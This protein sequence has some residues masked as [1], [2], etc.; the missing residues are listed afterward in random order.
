MNLL[1]KLTIKNLKLNKK[2]TIVT[3]I[4]IVLSIA[5]LTAVSS[6]YKSGLDAL[7]NYEKVITG[8]YH[9]KFSNVKKEDLDKINLHEG[10][11]FASVT[12]G[13]G[14]AKVPSVNEAKPYVYILGYTKDSFNQLGVKLE[15][16]RLPE[17]DSEVLVPNHLYTNGRVNYQIGDKITLDVGSRYINGEEVDQT[18][19]YEKEETF[20]AKTKKEY[21]VVGTIGSP[22]RQVEAFSAPGYSLIT[23]YDL[24]DT[25]TYNVYIRF[26]ANR[27]KD[28]YSYIAD[29]EGINKDIFVKAT[30]PNYLP[31]QEESEEFNKEFKKAKYEM[32]INQ[33]LLEFEKDPIRGSAMGSLSK[34]IMIVLIII[35]V[36]SVFC[37]KNS[38]DISITEKTKQYGMLRSVGATKKQIRKN[39]LYEATILG[40]IGIPIGIILGLIATAILMVITNK[41]MAGAY[42]ASMELHMVISWAAILVSI[43]LGVVTIYLSALRSSIRAS[44]VSPIESIRNSANIKLKKKSLKVPKIISKIFKI[45]GEISYKNIKRNKKKFRTTVISIVISVA[46]FIGL[47]YFME[48]MVDSIKTEITYSDHNINV[49]IDNP[50]DKT[51]N[52]YL[53]YKDIDYVEKLTVW[54]R[55][56]ISPT[57]LKNTKE[58]IDYEGDEYQ[59]YSAILDVV[60]LDDD[61]YNTYLEELKADKKDLKDSGVLINKL[62]REKKKLNEFEIKSGDTISGDKEYNDPDLKVGLVT[63]V[64]PF[65]LGNETSNTYYVMSMSNFQKLFNKSGT[66]LYIAIQSSNANKTQDRLEE[67]LKN[68][69]NSYNIENIDENVR[70]MKNI[71]L[72]IGIF[73]YGFI[74]VITLIGVTNIFNTITSNIA[75]RSQEFAMLKSIGMTKKEFDN[76]IRLESIFIGI[77][78]L[79]FGIPLGLGLSYLVYLSVGKN[80]LLSYSIPF[81]PIIIASITVFLLITILMRYSVKKCEN[82]NIIET[83][84]NE[85]I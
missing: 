64:R 33:Y 36:T 46:V 82:Q 78:A 58:F 18:V 3:I 47:T 28:A 24:K 29:F 17:N 11:E 40:L 25:D 68:E 72:L 1:N 15:K 69:T 39:V 67:V 73:L 55:S 19:P 27:L 84:R 60:A 37:I 9:V 79:L 45:G 16:G 20:K 5:L 51:F 48:A 22:I 23:L 50:V 14:Y 21:T 12:H 43:M 41:L 74:T 4:G 77:K 13:V 52:T 62:I 44:H 81:K 49:T 76:M 54:K 8:N 30:D 35:V 56:I 63:D 26:K 57:N 71:V 10:V 38:F 53:N 70:E 75:L 32:H 2:R 61:S 7:I 6:F 34:V 85:N 42:D 80:E 31:S 59:H 65:S 83:I 66:S